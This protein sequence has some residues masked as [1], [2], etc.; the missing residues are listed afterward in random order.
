METKVK[1]ALGMAFVLLIIIMGIACFKYADVLFK[2]EVKM[3]YSD[4]CVEVYVNGE[5]TTD[6]CIEG[7]ALA[8][9]HNHNTPLPW[10]LN[11]TVNE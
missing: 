1:I 7:R 3:T 8:D 5:L 4:N 11:L 2:N 6:E 9:A 10:E